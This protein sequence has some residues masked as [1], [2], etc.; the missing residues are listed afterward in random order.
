V[1]DLAEVTAALKSLQDQVSS[2]HF[3][4]VASCTL[5]LES[6]P[7]ST[8]N[9]EFVG[10]FVSDADGN[11]HGDP[12]SDG[13]QWLDTSYDGCKGKAVQEGVPMFI[14]EWPA[15]H[16]ANG[17]ASCGHMQTIAHGNYH[18]AGHSGS[19]RAPDTDCMSEVDQA[20]HPLGG[21][22]RFAAY[23][24]PQVAECLLAGLGAAMTT[25]TAHTVSECEVGPPTADPSN[26]GL[27]GCFVSDA[28]GTSHGDPWADGSTWSDSTWNDCQA[29][30]VGEG[31]SMFVMEWPQGYEAA[32]HASC[33]HMDVISHG[34]YHDAQH[35]G[36]GR[37]PNEDC[38]GEIDSQGHA[39]GGP[40]RFA[41]YAP[42]A[43]TTCLN[44]D[45]ILPPPKTFS[46]CTGTPATAGDA[47]TFVGCFVSDGGNYADP[48]ADGTKWKDD[49][50]D[51]CHDRALAEGE[52]QF[53]MEGAN[54]YAA[55]GHASCGHSDVVSIENAGHAYH[56]AGHNG[57]GRAPDSDC[58]IKT[59][60]K[61]HA[62]GGPFRFAAYAPTE[63]AACIKESLGAAPTT[64]MAHSVSEC[65]T[66]APNPAANMWMYV[67]CF[68]SD[69]DGTSH[70]DPWSDGS[71]WADDTWAG[72][73]Q[74]AVSLEQFSAVQFK[75][76]QS[77]AV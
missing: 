46:S 71:R 5:K 75:A 1:E 69:A 60:P 15:G 26:W 48:W 30:A 67:G 44:N 54:N 70:A 74:R 21:P 16:A 38:M 11:S 2:A 47:F 29:K 41:A 56:D 39:L 32:D 36:G 12:W 24:P 22:W 6:A 7:T 59:D 27:V 43:V 76:V 57:N 3:R 77:L 53:V 28:D 61:G 20:H 42:H 13:S 35:N 8:T 66:G 65:T 4:E 37:A 23:A 52:S 55:A 33:G 14:M 73:Q 9:Y 45:G 58:M 34:H 51:G 50:W 64:Q 40:W 25:K 10:C 62:L 49:T 17:A 19:G 72:C 18:D 63:E 31:V 68:V